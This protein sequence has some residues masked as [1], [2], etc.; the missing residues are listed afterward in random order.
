MAG[1]GVTGG[2]IGGRLAKLREVRR[3]A[4]C[5][6][7]RK[8]VLALVAFFRPWPASRLK[9]STTASEIGMN[10]TSST[11]DGRQFEMRFASLFLQGRG[12]AFPCDDAGEVSLDQ[13]SERARCNYFFAR[14]M[15]GREYAA[16]SVCV[17]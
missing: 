7:R 14:A 12:L 2:Y 13:L 6:I 5:F 17:A 16:P 8:A 1:A 15:V 9:T 11:G 10:S 4:D 3:Q